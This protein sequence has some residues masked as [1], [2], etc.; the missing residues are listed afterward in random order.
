[1]NHTNQ[2]NQ[3]PSKQL[4]PTKILAEIIMMVALAGALSYISHGFFRLPQGGS[5]NLGM[6]P[7]FWVALRRGWKIGVFSGA[8]FGV[9]DLAFEPFIVNPIQFI[10]DYPLPFALLGLAG[11]FKA[12]P[13]VGVVVGGIGRFFSHFI[14]GVVYFADYAPAGMSPIVYSAVYNGTYLIPSIIICAVVIGILQ[15]SKVLNIYL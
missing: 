2:T 3:K 13:V 8:V 4:I 12:Y 1:M 7:I 9:V 11:L 15:K 6:I 10:L 14:S 5:I